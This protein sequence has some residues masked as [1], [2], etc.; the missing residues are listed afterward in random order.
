MSRWVAMASSVE[1]SGESPHER[2]SRRDLNKE[3]AGMFVLH[4][5]WRERRFRKS[6]SP[7]RERGLFQMRQNPFTADEQF[8]RRMGLVEARGTEDS[9]D[10]RLAV[11]V[12]EQGVTVTRVT[13]MRIASDESSSTE[14]TNHNMDAPE[15]DAS[16]HLF[17]SSLVPD[18]A[19]ISEVRDLLRTNSIP[20]DASY[21]RSV[22]AGSP[23]DI[24]RYDIDIKTLHA[25]LDKTV[26][27]RD[28]LQV[29]AE[30]CRSVLAPIRNLPPEILL[31]IFFLSSQPAEFDGTFASWSRTTPRKHMERL[32]KVDL[33]Q[34]SRVCSTWHAVVMGTPSL[35]ATIEVNL[36]EWM[37]PSMARRL[38]YLL[39]A[40]L[41]RAENCPLTLKLRATG[42]LYETAPL[43]L[44][45]QRSDRWHSANLWI[46]SAA[47]R[48][49]SFTK[50]NFPLLE[51]LQIH[52]DFLHEL[53]I[54]E[55]APLLS[56]VILRSSGAV[57]PPQLPWGQLRSL[58][59]E[60]G[61]AA[62][63]RAFMPLIRLCPRLTAVTFMAVNVSALSLPLDLPRV[64]SNLH[65]LAIMLRNTNDSHPTHSARAFSNLIRSF[66]LPCAREFR[67]EMHSLRPLHWPHREFRALISRSSCGGTVTSLTLRNIVIK[68]GHLL[69]CLEH[70][71]R[72]ETLVLADIRK[73]TD[74][75][76]VDHIVITNT[77]LRRLT[78]TSDGASM[79]P[80]LRVLSFSSLFRFTAQVLVDCV[81]SRVQ[82]AR[83][84]NRPFE[85]HIQPVLD[86]VLTADLAALQRRGDI[87]Y[88]IEAAPAFGEI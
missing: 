27:E 10:G 60:D 51:S 29:H 65:S 8:L 74:G 58:N 83:S 49:T 69:E 78:L 56:Q 2:G 85:L 18:S 71:P 9:E 80:H 88:S 19:Q 73:V 33:L 31:R 81:T 61:N 22:I 23:A 43:E 39:I 37:M 20:P 86:V 67:F 62:D 79:A 52:G 30:R 87:W 40:A 16:V 46:E 57:Q 34:L 5:L 66:K 7:A 21:F 47:F 25:A 4:K 24:R 84:A 28:A 63:L 41:E 3:R 17:C 35:W 38:M 32:A 44:L 48:H 1:A 11:V 54:F 36:T 6:A 72:L 42:Q 75:P 26:S 64:T 77:L 55:V 14:S 15:K 12:G 59:Y 70:F 82:A 53:D 76:T 13:S 50:R 68:E 45:A